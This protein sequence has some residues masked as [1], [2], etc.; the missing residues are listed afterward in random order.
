MKKIILAMTALAASATL[1]APAMAAASAKL[2]LLECAISGGAG[3]VIGSQKDLS[4]TFTPADKSMPSEA[5]FG[6]VTKY[7]LD[8]GVTGG[9]VMQWAVLAPTDVV[10]GP[11]AL[12]GDYVG[13]S[14]EATAAIGAGAN[15]LVGG[16]DVTYAL[17]PLSIQGQTGVNVAVGVSKFE[18]RSAN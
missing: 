3:F 11:G 7:G 16:S 15:V 10:Y 9:A 13:A 17:Q 12:A 8:V 2:G 6:G 18:L 14:A 5:Y 1:A 4:C